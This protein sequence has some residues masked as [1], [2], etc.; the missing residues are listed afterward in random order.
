MPTKGTARYGHDQ[1]RGLEDRNQAD[2]PQD[3]YHVKPPSR[4]SLQLWATGVTEKLRQA[5]PEKRTS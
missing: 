5:A 3:I 2:S 4:L 1:D